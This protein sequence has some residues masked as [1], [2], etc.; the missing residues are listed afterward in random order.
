MLFACFFLPIG[1]TLCYSMLTS[2][3]KQMNAYME[4]FVVSGYCIQY[5]QDVWLLSRLRVVVMIPKADLVMPAL[6]FSITTVLGKVSMLF[7]NNMIF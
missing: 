3:E 1:I 7:L 2:Q 4:K 5:K 6:S